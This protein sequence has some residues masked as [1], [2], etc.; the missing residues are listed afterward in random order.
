MPDAM[1]KRW[2]PPHASHGG[3]AA[4]L[5]IAGLGLDAGSWQPQIEPLA[6]G[7]RVIVFDARG[8]GAAPA[9]EP[10]YSIDDMAEDAVAVLDALGIG[11]AH[12][13]GFSMGG[14]VAQTLAVR[15]PGRAASLTLAATVLRLPPRSRAVI[16]AW[17]RMAAAGLDREP[18]V[19]EQV[20]WV[21]TDRVLADAA[22]TD[23]IVAGLCQ[24][25]FSAA[26][27]TGQAA[28]CLGFDSTSW[29]ANIAVPTLVVAG[30]ED[31]LIPIAAS[32]A[33]AATIPRARLAVLNGA[34]HG[35]PIEA[36]DAFNRVVLDFLAEGVA[37][38]PT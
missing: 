9:P 13:V 22:L 19:R 8:T 27:F 16:D 1:T 26:G 6:H 12:V 29:A 35:F 21:F 20:A 34:G 4:V 24:A 32:E 25:P 5:L 33:L 7:H 14:L 38:S 11:R 10:P 2:T 30:R 37:S 36:A 18:F 3:G 28:A 17:A 23:A 31:I 15:H